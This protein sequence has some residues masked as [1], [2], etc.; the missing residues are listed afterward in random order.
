MSGR[1]STVSVRPAVAGD[2]D[3]IVDDVWAVAAEGRWI[4]TELPFDRDKRGSVFRDAIASDRAAVFVADDGGRIVGHILVNLASYGVADI[5]M[6]IVE[7][8]RG[9]GIGTTLLDSAIGWAR[10]AGAHKMYLEVWPH[11]QAAL[12]LYRKAGF[13]EEGRKRRHYQRAN[14]EVWDAILMGLPL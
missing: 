10:G 6:A 4:G 5:G 3:A 7:G 2:V 13:E 11:N 12:A 8:Y 9:Q 14:G 1:T